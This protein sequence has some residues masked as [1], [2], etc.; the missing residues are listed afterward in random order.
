MPNAISRILAKPLIGLVGLYRLAISPWLG[1]NCRYQ[2][3]CSRYAIEALR[4]HGAW[5]G[6]WLAAKRIARCHPWGDSGYDPVPTDQA[7]DYHRQPS[8]L[9]KKRTAVLNHAYGFVSR[10][11]REGGFNHIFEWLGNDPEPVAAWAWFFDRMLHWENQVTAMFF[12]Q[13]YLHDQLRHGEQVPAVKL[14]MRCRLV[15]E[16]FRPLPEDLPAAIA[17]CEAHDNDEL[18]AILRRN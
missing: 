18:A 7:D 4:E 13:H 6:S 10:D 5:R 3:T 15:D 8:D 16:S 1:G 9:E 12:A 2:P 14:I 17:A 11:N